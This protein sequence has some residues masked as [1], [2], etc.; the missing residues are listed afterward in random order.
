MFY[1]TRLLQTILLAM[2]LIKSPMGFTMEHAFDSI[3]NQRNAH[4][5]LTHSL[6][7]QH[8]SQSLPLELYEHINEYLGHSE[9]MMIGLVSKA[10]RDKI[11]DKEYLNCLKE[12]ATFFFESINIHNHYTQKRF[13]SLYDFTEKVQFLADN[14]HLE[15]VKRQ[16]QANLKVNEMSARRY[17]AICEN[18]LDYKLN[19]GV[20]AAQI[21]YYKFNQ[22]KISQDDFAYLARIYNYPYEGK[23]SCTI[24]CLNCNGHIIRTSFCC[25]E[26]TLAG[27]C[28]IPQHLSSCCCGSFALFLI[29]C[30]NC[31]ILK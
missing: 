11:R 28:C 13:H 20:H 17:L 21:E 24:C 27:L 12:T 29:F 26:Y 25:A 18:N 14:A 30:C 1:L 22:I 2:I 8:I 16:A 23:N 7:P 15:E 9:K 4:V 6:K 10:L 5:K 19:E 31:P 3:E